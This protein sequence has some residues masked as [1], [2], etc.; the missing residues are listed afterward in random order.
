MMATDTPT[1]QSRLDFARDLISDTVSKLPAD[2][3]GLY[4]YTSDVKDLVP[5]TLDHLYLRMMLQKTEV[6]S[7]GIAGTDLRKVLGNLYSRFWAKPSDRAIS[8]VLITDGGD[9]TLEGLPDDQRADYSKV[10]ARALGNSSTPRK[11][12]TI[13]IGSKAGQNLTDWTI[14]ADPFIRR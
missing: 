13:G 3:I 1:G 9:T 10:I 8:L 14:R 6:N 11:V 12:V 7:V 2:N 4:L 5:A